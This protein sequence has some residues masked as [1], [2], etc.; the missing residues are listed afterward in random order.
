MEEAV[1]EEALKRRNRIGGTYFSE[2]NLHLMHANADIKKSVLGFGYL[3]DKEQMMVIMIV[4]KSAPSHVVELFSRIS[5]SLIEN[6]Q[7]LNA[8]RV[9]DRENIL[10]IILTDILSLISTQ[11]NK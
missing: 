4:S 5:M 8:I 7:L 1:I 6:P 3:K 10:S 2:L 9:L 11:C